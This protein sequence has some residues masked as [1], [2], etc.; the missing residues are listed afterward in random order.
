EHA[1]VD[2]AVEAIEDAA[3]LG[4]RRG[5]F[6]ERF[7]VEHEPWVGYPPYPRTYAALRRRAPSRSRHR[8]RPRPRRGGHRDGPSRGGGDA[9]RRGRRTGP[10]RARPP[11]GDLLRFHGPA[12]GP[13]R[14][15]A[16]ARRGP[17]LRRAP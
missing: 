16:R 3:R 2:T 7:R 10:A 11:R 6:W 5:G 13:G 9:P 17:D 15:R 4:R 12:A 1:R 14:G 8:P